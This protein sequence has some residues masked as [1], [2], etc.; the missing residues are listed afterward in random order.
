MDVSMI[1]MCGVLEVMCHYKYRFESIEVA[2]TNADFCLAVVD[3]SD[4]SHRVE[5]KT[6]HMYYSQV[7]GQLAITK[8]QFCDFVVYTTKDLFI[9]KYSF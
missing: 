6:S 5:L 4:G 8:R 1:Y 9:K 2:A 7:Q 3:K